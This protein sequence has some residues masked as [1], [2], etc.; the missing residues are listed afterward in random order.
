MLMIWTSNEWHICYKIGTENL[1][2]NSAPCIPISPLFYFFLVLK[3]L[4]YP[5]AFSLYSLSE[6]GF[7]LGDLSSSFVDN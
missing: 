4:L 2:S 7:I 1:D 3:T 6:F 5:L